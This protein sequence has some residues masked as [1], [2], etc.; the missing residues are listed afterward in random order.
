MAEY[1]SDEL[2]SVVADIE[3]AFERFDGVLSRI[4]SRKPEYMAE[5]ELRALYRSL[6]SLFDTFP[7]ER[8]AVRIRERI[9][10]SYEKVLMERE[11]R[12]W[13]AIAKCE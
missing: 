8:W 11:D 4:E 3:R 5:E 13:R 1:L 2:E 10:K 7:P 12:R 9:R 6:D